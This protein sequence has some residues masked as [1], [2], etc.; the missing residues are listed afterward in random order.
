MLKITDAQIQNYITPYKYGQPVLHGSG[1]EGCFDSNGVDIPFVFFHRGKFH[2]MYAGYDGE[3]YQTALATSDNLLEWEHKGII[4]K[5]LNEERWDKVGAA[6]TWILKESDELF[7]LPV[8]KKVDGKYWL[9]YHSY[10]QT[11][12]ESGPAEIGLA[13]SKDEELLEW[14]RLEQPVFSWKEGKDWEKGGLY[15]ACIVQ[16]D[17]L[18]YLFYNAKTEG[19]SWVEQTGMAYS[20]DLMNWIRCEENPLL[21]IT[22]SGWETKFLSDPCVIRDGDKWLNF[23]FA[24]DMK[25][26]RE[27]LAISHDLIHW[28]KVEEPI[29]TNGKVG[30]IDEIHAHKAS[31]ICYEGRM[32]HFYCAV[33]PYREGDP[34][35]VCGEYR[36][37]SVASSVPFI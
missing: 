2:M 36:T 34:T 9:V 33:R 29:V 21:K 14:N 22:T 11:G 24:Y 16:R 18:F 4:L 7:E 23:Y 26:A 3:G 35:N 31:V 28:E 37:I 19:L 6:A 10:P 13:W 25:H 32:Y 15:K 20:K 8:L 5:R 12:Y 27:G 30:E 17:D 1:I